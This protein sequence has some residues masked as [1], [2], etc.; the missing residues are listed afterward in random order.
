MIKDSTSTMKWNRTCLR[1]NKIL[2]Y[3]SKK[4]L[5]DTLTNMEIK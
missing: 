1:C 5:Y 4:S 3:T 2:N